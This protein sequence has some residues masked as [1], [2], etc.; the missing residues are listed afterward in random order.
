M[1][2]TTVFDPG[3]LLQ[4]DTDMLDAVSL[5]INDTDP[6]VLLITLNDIAKIK[7]IA[8]LAKDT[9]LNRESL[10]KTLSAKNKPKWETIHK[11]M[12]ALDI[13]LQAVG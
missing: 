9:G 10:Y 3:S 1:T 5:A 2:K 11:I 13:K 7:G 12:L 4:T 6:N 8:N